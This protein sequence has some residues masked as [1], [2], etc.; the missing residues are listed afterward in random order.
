M[1]D[2]VKNPAFPDH[3]LERLRREHLTDLRRGLD[4]AGV[5]A[6]RISPGLVFPQHTGYGHPVSGTEESVSAM[7]RQDILEKFRRDYGPASATLI[8][9]GDVTMDEVY[10]Q[11]EAHLGSWSGNGANGNVP[12]EADHHPFD[13]TTIYLVDR[14][15]A[16]QSV[17]RAV[18]PTINR[19]HPDYFAL[20]LLNYSFGGQFSARLNSNLRQ[21]KGYSYGYN[22]SVQWHRGPSLLQAGGSV[23]TA[24]TKESVQE[25]LKEF[26]DIHG[27]RPVTQE[28]LDASKAG[29][30]L[31]YPAGFERPSMIL[32][33]LL[34]L[35]QYRLPNDYFQTV[36]SQLDAV[37]LAD[38][39]RVAA[40]QIRPSNLKVL[41]V[42]D[43]EAVEPGLRELGLPLVMLDLRGNKL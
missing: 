15:G 25:T 34:Q 2:L 39:H 37:S 6:A 1:A 5:I 41:V 4:D 10:A 17:I 21:D 22:S 3:E 36:R 18:Q 12:G 29:I 9:A 20:T 24:V 14:P 19:H 42:G 35:V 8:V 7:T 27:S 30:L 32:G 38:V 28:E 43:R 33:H 16:A 31:G 11:A 23:Q 26:S 40:E 13:E